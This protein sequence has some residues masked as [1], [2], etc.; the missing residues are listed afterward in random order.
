MAL[1]TAGLVGIRGGGGLGT[2]IGNSLPVFAHMSFVGA[3]GGAGRG[4]K[5]AS[6][7]EGVV[8]TTEGAWGG[9]GSSGTGAGGMTGGLGGSINADSSGRANFRVGS[10]NGTIVTSEKV[11]S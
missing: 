11:D 5:G 4:A 2:T 9:F 8:C 6:A 7:E 1:F 10:S 3:G